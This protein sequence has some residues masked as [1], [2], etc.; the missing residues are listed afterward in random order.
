VPNETRTTP[1]G[2][3]TIQVQMARKGKKSRP[4]QLSNLDVLGRSG[5]HI[6]SAKQNQVFSASGGWRKVVRASANL[7]VFHSMLP[8]SASG[9]RMLPFNYLLLE[10]IGSFEPLLAPVRLGRRTARTFPLF[11]PPQKN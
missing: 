5:R 2:L 11:P 10:L 7:P 4:I 3:P 8:G 6:R 1:S 9:G